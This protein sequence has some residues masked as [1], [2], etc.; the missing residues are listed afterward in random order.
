M[1]GKGEGYIQT[2]KC[3]ARIGVVGEGVAKMEIHFSLYSKKDGVRNI[4]KGEH[5]DL[6]TALHFLP[7]G[8]HSIPFSILNCKQSLYGSWM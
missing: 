5:H 7:Q 1:R 6:L 4:L 8:Q 2:L 3:K